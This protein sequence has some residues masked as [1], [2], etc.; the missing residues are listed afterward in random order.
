M[1]YSNNM[2]MRRSKICICGISGINWKPDIQPVQEMVITSPKINLGIQSVNKV[3]YR[4]SFGCCGT[5]AKYP[6]R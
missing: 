3:S 2:H 5:T 6:R 1:Q 4:Q